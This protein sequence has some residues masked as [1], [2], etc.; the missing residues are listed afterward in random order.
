M[1]ELL[2]LLLATFLGLGTYYIC[3]GIVDIPTNK[4]SKMMLMAKKQ[5]TNKEK[6]VDVYLTKVAEK[7]SF[8]LRL[9]AIKKEK[10]KNTL[11][12]AG[13][14]I[15][16][17][18]Y[19]L[20]AFLTALLTGFLALPFFL[21]MPFMGFLLL[22]LAVM[23]WFSSYYKAF[24][25]VKKRKKRMETE[26]PR[27]TISIQQSLATDRD[28]LKILI[29]YRRIAGVHLAQE[30][31]TTIADMKT[32][33]YENALLRFQNRVGSNMLNDII[34]G[35]IGTLRGDDQQMYFKMLS[36]DMRQIEQN[37]LMKEAQKRPKQMQ[38]YSMMLLF[39]ILF[40]YVVVLSVE[41]VGSLGSFF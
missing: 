31:D 5:G 15:S 8:L 27:F 16:P 10:L 7:F 14:Q 26:L 4:T 37:N 28:V 33:N 17:E 22:G 29:A 25:Y 12:I 39:C 20:K 41:V 1:V 35:L 34:R 36:H 23:M 38:K 6:L 30:L 11:Q 3:C 21:I 18:C 19:T 40:I 9:D 32:G 13:I 24:D 2:I